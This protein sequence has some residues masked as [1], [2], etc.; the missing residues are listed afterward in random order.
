[1]I[2]N[3]S[4]IFGLLISK[5]ANPHSHLLLGPLAPNSPP[6]CIGMFLKCFCTSW[7]AFALAMCTSCL[8]G[9]LLLSRYF[10]KL[11]L[12]LVAWQLMISRAIAT[13]RSFTG[14]RPFLAEKKVCFSQGD[15]CF[16]LLEEVINK[17]EL[18]N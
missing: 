9:R 13:A 5:Q 18:S 1:M 8:F 3:K 14:G 17:R 16:K 11:N 2:N 7:W 10:C 4:K 15:A 12:V 6:K